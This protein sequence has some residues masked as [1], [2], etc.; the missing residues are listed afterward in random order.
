MWLDFNQ[1]AKYLEV[2]LKSIM[3]FFIGTCIGTRYIIFLKYLSIFLKKQ[4]CCLRSESIFS[5][6]MEVEF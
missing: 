6:Y 3:E 2:N 5:F 4:I 1:Q